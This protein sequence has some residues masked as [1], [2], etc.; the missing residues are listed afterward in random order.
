MTST[1]PRWE[2]DT[3]PP[4][5]RNLCLELSSKY[6]VTV[7]APHFPGANVLENDE[8]LTVRR[9]RYCYTPWQQLSYQGG[10]LENLK[11][12]KWTLFLVPLFLVSLFFAIFRLLRGQTFSLI[13]AHWL[14]PQGLAVIVA[15][16]I[17][18]VPTP[19]VVTSHGGDLFAL[20]SAIF[21]GLKTRIMKDAQRV[22]VVSQKMREIC[23]DLGVSEN[24]VDVISMGVDTQDTF[25]PSSDDRREAQRVLFVGRLAEKKGVQYAIEAVARLT[26]AHPSLRLIV[27]GDGPERVELE[28]RTR[29]LGID[30]VVDFLGSVENQRLPSIYQSCEI[31]LLP[32]VIA[33]SGDQEG[34]PVTGLEA[35]A[36]ECAVVAFDLPA[37]RELIQ[38]GVSGF[39]VESRS[40]DEL[41]D[42]I[43]RLLRDSALSRRLGQT[44]RDTVVDRYSWQSIGER[45]S[46]LFNSLID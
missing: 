27:V 42:R 31:F 4:F 19:V 11:N 30:Q 40:A 38:D 7:L 10:I 15:K 9:F 17:L 1:F 36:C 21:R 8:G 5:V 34:L 24:H 39:L 41:V 32:S 22:A 46:Q 25:R 37:T 23:I 16:K 28:R 3:E 12:R 18:R 45:Y 14:I 13:H 35:M 43:D 29:E 26:P 44:A 6:S 2:G 20:K 33:A